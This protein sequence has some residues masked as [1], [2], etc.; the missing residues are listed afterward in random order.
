MRAVRLLA[1]TDVPGRYLT[2]VVSRGNLD[3]MEPLL[4]F[5]EQYRFTINFLVAALPEDHPLSLRRCTEE[6]LRVFYRAL[7]RWS[8]KNGR[9]YII[10]QYAAVIRYGQPVPLNTC[11]FALNTLVIDSDGSLFPCYQ[12]KGE[13]LGASSHPRRS[14]CR[15]ERKPSSSR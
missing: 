7:N 4:E 10:G 5:A 1:D 3:Q 14:R 8:E 9:K 13:P 12:H 11:P 2:T 15:R 6:E